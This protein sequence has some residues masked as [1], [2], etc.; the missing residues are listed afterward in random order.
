MDAGLAAVIAGAAGAGGA[1][2]AAFGTSLGLLRQAKMQGSHAHQ[3]WLRTHQQQAC[4]QLMIMA[5]DVEAACRKVMLAAAFGHPGGARSPEEQEIRELLQDVPVQTR[6]MQGGVYRIV[7]LL[8]SETGENAMETLNAAICLSEATV[9]YVQWILDPTLPA[10]PRD[11]YTQAD[12][13][14]SAVRARFML[15]ARKMLQHN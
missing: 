3:Q 4:E 5:D 7:L 12:Q 6:A 15:R 14:A 2:L 13:A 8:D 11:Q 9:G 10:V 1:A